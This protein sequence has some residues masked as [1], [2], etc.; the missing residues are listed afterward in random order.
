MGTFINA[1]VPEHVKYYLIYP[2]VKSR[3]LCIG[4]RL[5]LHPILDVMIQSNSVNGPS[6]TGIIQLTD[7]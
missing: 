7:F 4:V 2:I 1:I 5:E 3:A 6:V